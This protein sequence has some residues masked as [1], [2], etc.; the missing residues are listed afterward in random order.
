M[1]Y[2]LL[3]FFFGV[4]GKW[5]WDLGIMRR[6]WQFIFR[7]WEF[8]HKFPLLCLVLGNREWE[9]KTIFTVTQLFLF[10]SNW[11]GNKMGRQYQHYLNAFEEE[12]PA[13]HHRR[14]GGPNVC[15]QVW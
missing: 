10:S 13:A 9:F 1:T 8:I 4:F 11:V 6:E 7:G 15:N 12:A 3:Y 2:V 14:V 5:D